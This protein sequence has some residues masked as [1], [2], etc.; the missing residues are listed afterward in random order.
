MVK[1]LALVAALGVAS[2]MADAGCAKS[3]KKEAP[4]QTNAPAAQAQSPSGSSK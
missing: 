4:A 2:A 1:A 3:E